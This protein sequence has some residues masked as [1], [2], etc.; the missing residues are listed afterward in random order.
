MKFRKERPFANVDG[1][2]RSAPQRQEEARPLA[3]GITGE[4]T[5]ERT[6]GACARGRGDKS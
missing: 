5:L 2:A 6:V 1:R 3:F 4:T